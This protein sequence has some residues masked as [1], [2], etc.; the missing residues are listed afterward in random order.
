MGEKEG[1]FWFLMPHGA[2][3]FFLFEGCGRLGLWFAASVRRRRR[4]H[5][6][7]LV[8]EVG[9]E[10]IDA[11]S[12]FLQIDHAA[13]HAAW[14]LFLL[15]ATAGHDADNNEES[16]GILWYGSLFVACKEEAKSTSSYTRGGISSAQ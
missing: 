4:L 9:S 6:A 8:L 2:V 15:V 7:G 10:V 5:T 16:F 11:A 1:R 14:I 13:F 12:S 3:F